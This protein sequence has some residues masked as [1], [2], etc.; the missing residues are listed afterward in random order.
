MEGLDYTNAIICRGTDVVDGGCC[1]DD[2]FELLTTDQTYRV[3]PGVNDGSAVDSRPCENLFKVNTSS[4]VSSG[5][6]WYFLASS[7]RPGHAESLGIPGLDV[8]GTQDIDWS[9]F[10]IYTQTS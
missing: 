7:M 3:R 8:S 5:G 9:Y 4:N 10:T 2:R 1:F 6:A